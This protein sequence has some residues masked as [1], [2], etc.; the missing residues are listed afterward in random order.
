M[1]SHRFSRDGQKLYYEE[2]GEGQ[3]I[4][5]IHSFLADRTMWDAEVLRFQESYRV[6]VV[7]L[8]GHG[9]AGASAP[10]TLYDMVDDVIAVLDHAGV[11]QAI[12]CGLSIGGMITV[13]AAIR[14]PNRVKAMLL[15]NTDGAAEA[16]KVLAKHK[17]LA[18]VVRTLGVKPVLT[19][20][21][22][23]MFGKTAQ[24]SQPALIETWRDKMALVH[25]PSMMRSLSALDNRDDVLKSLA[26]VEI[27]ALIIHGMEDSAI[28][29]SRGQS[30]ANALPNREFLLYEQLG[31]L[32]N[33]ERPEVIHNALASFIEDL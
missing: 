18:L 22:K 2:Y 29:H 5:F 19:Q 28:H 32:S 30:L 26:T 10:H 14:H 27:P 4:I 8:R 7:D 24:A 12:W 1:T 21:M 11:D 31:H 15:L 16:P 25:V 20:V 13:R 17:I 23:M 33:L 9:N 3:P 6:I